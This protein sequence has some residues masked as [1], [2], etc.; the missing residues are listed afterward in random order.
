MHTRCEKWAG[1]VAALLSMGVLLT[2]IQAWALEVGDQA[3]DF[4]MH[5]TVGD[6]VRLSDYQGKKHVLLF[7]F[8]AA[9]TSV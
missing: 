6:T 4:L 2:P 7:F 9:F 3:P 5:G 1:V 8:V